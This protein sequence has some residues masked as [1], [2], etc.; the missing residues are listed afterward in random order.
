[1]ESDGLVDAVDGLDTSSLHAHPLAG[2]EDNPHPLPWDYELLLLAVS[3]EV[4]RDC[5][6]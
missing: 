4:Q 1:M 5:H 3:R 6:L 2:G